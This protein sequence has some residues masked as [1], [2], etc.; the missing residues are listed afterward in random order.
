MTRAALLRYFC[1]H[2]Q[3]AI[4]KGVLRYELNGNHKSHYH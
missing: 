2:F 4:W 3:L 1:A